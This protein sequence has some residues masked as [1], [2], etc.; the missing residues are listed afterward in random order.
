MGWSY[1][2]ALIVADIMRVE[3]RLPIKGKE[4]LGTVVNL[5]PEEPR[6]ERRSQV[7]I[8]RDCV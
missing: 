1:G 2:N 4:A 6:N 7:S 5:G 8:C 3:N